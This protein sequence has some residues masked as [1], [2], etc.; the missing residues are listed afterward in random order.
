MSK[1]DA[2]D[3]HF[4]ETDGI[5]ATR[6]GLGEQLQSGLEDGQTCSGATKARLREVAN[7]HMAML[8]RTPERVMAYFQNRRLRYAA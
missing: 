3:L 5:G 7:E 2:I 8:D 1:H 4:L 6:V